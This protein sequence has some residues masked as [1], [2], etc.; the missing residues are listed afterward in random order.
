MSE[1]FLI[2]L[3]VIIA[4]GIIAQW[5]AWRLHLPSILLLLILG[6]IAG[7]VSGL[8]DTRKTVWRFAFSICV[9]LG[10]NH[11]I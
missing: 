6:I 11:F 1:Q 3:G 7:P 4:F 9:D 5:L 2:G 8:V 10:S